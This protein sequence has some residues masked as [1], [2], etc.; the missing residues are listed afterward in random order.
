MEVAV[1]PS[2]NEAF[3]HQCLEKKKKLAGLLGV[4]AVSPELGQNVTSS[5]ESVVHRQLG[6][7]SCAGGFLAWVLNSS[8]GK[9]AGL[10]VCPL[11]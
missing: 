4:C 2:G 5:R 9:K 3:H 1:I 11:F 8:K 6:C 10:K 7:L